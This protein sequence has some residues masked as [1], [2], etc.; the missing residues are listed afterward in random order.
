MLTPRY[1]FSQDFQQFQDYFLSRPHRKRTFQKGDCLWEPGR[2]CEKIHYFLSGAAIHYTD[3]ESGRR[4]IISFHGAG[5]VF[6]GY[7]RTDYRIELSLVTTALTEIRAL[8]FT[9]PQFQEM[10]ETNTALSEQVVNWYA[11]YVNRFLF[12]AVH[13]E[14]N[15]SLV[16]ICNLLYLLSGSPSISSEPPAAPS[17]CAV[18]EAG[19]DL[20]QEELAGLL[21]LSR[22][23]L[24]RGLGELRSRGIIS[25]SR[26]R[27]Q[28]LNLPL[29][30]A[31][32][33]SETL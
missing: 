12:E 10:F 13:Q 7:H 33:T 1:F 19:I 29:L 3:H 16:K 8:E 2:P 26:C 14:Y 6:P 22:V 27:I 24:T 28:V 17:E 25:T 4:K 5:T 20:T 18:S 32:C 15:S 30:A 11:M 31:L 21:G 23:Q 9:V